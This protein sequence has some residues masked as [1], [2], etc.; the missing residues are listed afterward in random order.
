MQKIS[1]IAELRYEVAQLQIKQSLQSQSLKE[2]FKNVRESLR[3]VNLIKSTFR[4]VVNSP[5]LMTNVLNAGVGL[6]AGILTKRMFV[7]ST[8]NPFKRLLGTLLE[9]GMATI[10]TTKGDSIR[11][12]AT[13]LF[14]SVFSKKTEKSQD[15]D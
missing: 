15:D 6:A 11:D 7:G 5:D 13:H 2:Q 4:E 8:H 9:A 14:N 1:T 10:V 3:P 12:A